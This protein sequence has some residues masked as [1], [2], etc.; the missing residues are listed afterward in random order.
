M[1]I[2]V[3]SKFN[4]IVATVLDDMTSSYYESSEDKAEEETAKEDI[5]EETMG[6]ATS[7][8]NITWIEE[9]FNNW[10][11]FAEY[12]ELAFVSVVPFCCHSVL[13]T[14]KT[15]NLN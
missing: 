10:K 5:I 4:D 9:R 8:V 15:P 12:E 14:K 6:C 1:L 7:N 3:N 13:L 2:Y 11:Y